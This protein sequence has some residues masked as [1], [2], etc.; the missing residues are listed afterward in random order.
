MLF[1]DRQAKKSKPKPYKIIAYGLMNSQA[2][3]LLFDL[4]VNAYVR[5]YG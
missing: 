3:N 1:A 5:S 4:G 2:S